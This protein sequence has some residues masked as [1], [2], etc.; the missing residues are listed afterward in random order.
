[1]TRGTKW[2]ESRNRKKLKC[3]TTEK[4]LAYNMLAQ[5]YLVRSRFL[6]SLFSM[7]YFLRP[8]VTSVESVTERVCMYLQQLNDM[9][10]FDVSFVYY[11]AQLYH[12]RACILSFTLC[13]LVQLYCCE[14]PACMVYF[15][16]STSIYTVIQIYNKG[17][18]VKLLYEA[19]IQ[20]S[21]FCLI[22]GRSLGVHFAIQAQLRST[23]TVQGLFAD[24]LVWY[25]FHDIHDIEVLSAAEITGALF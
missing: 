9:V 4:L 17:Q 5:S 12:C 8:A 25:N 2:G 3:C 1:M 20:I 14:Y 15:L 11:E 10:L 6:L 24:F 23:Q 19:F 7:I 22:T 16:F 18:I 13:L 21:Y